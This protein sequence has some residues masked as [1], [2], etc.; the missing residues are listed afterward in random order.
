[1]LNEIIR[2]IALQ[3]KA[4]KQLRSGY[5]DELEDLVEFEDENWLYSTHGEHICCIEKY[6]GVQIELPLLS[7]SAT[8][9][10]AGHFS[11]YLKSI[12]KSEKSFYEIHKYLEAL[13][14]NGT[15]K[16]VQLNDRPIIWVLS[17][18][19]KI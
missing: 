11:V 10:D 13:E 17:S 12:G 19:S 1:M 2:Y 6:S 9:I 8:G 16:Q 18:N 15:L 7:P 14:R 4:L 3:K 5:T